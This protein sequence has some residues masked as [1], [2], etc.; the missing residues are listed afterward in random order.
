MKRQIIIIDIMKENSFYRLQSALQGY[1]NATVLI[2]VHVLKNIQKIKNIFCISSLAKMREGYL[3]PNQA[4]CLLA[5]ELPKRYS[6]KTKQ[7]I[8]IAI[9]M[10]I[11][12]NVKV[13]VI[14][15]SKEVEKGIKM[16]GLDFNLKIIRL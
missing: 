12:N 4:N 13:T 6:P 11:K 5:R 14:T 8:S 10:W 3:Y 1:K 2:P 7:T 9:T 16:Q 15:D